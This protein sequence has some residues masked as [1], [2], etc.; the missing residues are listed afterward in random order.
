MNLE[1]RKILAVVIGVGSYND[2]GIIRSCGEAGI[3]SVYITPTQKQV[4]PIFKSK[5]VQKAIFNEIT[6]DNILRNLSDLREEYKEVVIVVFPASD[7]AVDI[8]DRHYNHLPP[9]VYTSEAAGQIGTL[10]DKTCMADMASEAGLNIPETFEVRRSDYNPCVLHR[11]TFPIIIKP[12]RSIDGEKSDITVCCSAEEATKAIDALFE[13]RYQELLVQSY[14]H[15]D[16][17]REIGITGVSYGNGDIEIHGIIDKI[18]NRS[19]INNF[20]VYQ[21]N[22]SVGCEAALKAYITHT[23]YVGIFDTDFIEYEGELYF[24]ECNFR[25]GAYG[26]ATTHAGFNMPGQWIGHLTG[27]PRKQLKLKTTVFMEERT[28]LLNVLDGTFTLS[29]WLKDV[30]KTDVFLFWNSKDIRPM[31]RIPAF[32]KKMLGTEGEE[33]LVKLKRLAMSI[34]PP[35]PPKGKR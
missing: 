8:L 4:I 20:G 15:N 21:P 3:K 24:I 7:N 13:S 12:V 16:T 11:F 28:D 17:S 14:I 25:N 1:K 2:L 9:H 23:G 35:P 33:G 32:I 27:Q 18:R 30:R 34:L 19:N 10:M 29:S 26:Y 6:D 22:V 31:I 5:Y